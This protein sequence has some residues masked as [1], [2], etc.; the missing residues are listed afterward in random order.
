MNHCQAR[1]VVR[2]LTLVFLSLFVFVQ[3]A[4]GQY[5]P[6]TPNERIFSELKAVHP[7]SVPNE[8]ACSGRGGVLF[9]G[10]G[11]SIA[12]LETGNS[13]QEFNE[14]RRVP[15][16]R[17][18]VRPAA[19]L[20]DPDATVDD[21]SDADAADLLYIAGGHSGLWAIEANATAFDPNDP[22]ATRLDDS[23]NLNPSTQ[24]SRRWC[25][26]LATMTVDGVKYLLML[27]A[28]AGANRL[29]VYRL[30]ELRSTFALAKVLG[31]E[32]G[33]E[34][35][36]ALH[37]KVSA[38]PHAVSPA[39]DNDKAFLMGIDVLD[40]DDDPSLA[41]DGAW[42]YLAA[43]PHGL[44]RVHFPIG[45]SFDESNPGFPTLEWGPIF[46]D[47]TWYN[48]P[49]NPLP[50]SWYKNFEV[51]DDPDFVYDDPSDP[52]VT[53]SVPPFFIDVGVH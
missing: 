21:G 39:H 36:P 10:E 15:V 47:G 17:F 4:V 25:N 49:S 26:D 1:R 53:R 16:G 45:F 38:S 32:V 23:A 8:I 11:G 6:T 40:E 51:R 52:G 19:M 37:I 29:R 27:S 44:A 22:F 12:Y 46:G 30:S 7:F 31:V 50:S 5:V 41:S 2:S 13:G 18:G 20:L 24:Q 43:G 42:V 28:K 14:V 35:A 9:S 3:S 48:G 33:L 34:V